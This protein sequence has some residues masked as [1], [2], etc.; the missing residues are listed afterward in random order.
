MTELRDMSKLSEQELLAIIAKQNSPAQMAE[1]L[2]DIGKSAGVGLGEA[3]IGMAGLPGDV[4]ALA[5]KG[6]DWVGGKGARVGIPTPMPTS[7]TIKSRVEELT[8]PFYEPQTGAG[9]F[10]RGI[11]EQAPGV[12]FPGGPVRRAI[13]V[14]APAAGAEAGEALTGGPGGRVAGALIGGLAGTR[15]ITPAPATPERAR[16][17]AILEGEGV[18]LTA[19]QR[20]GNKPLQWFEQAAADTPFAAGRAAALNEA[21]QRGFSGAVMRRIGA[22]GDEIATGDAVQRAARNLSTTFEDLSARNTLTADRQF[23]NDLTQTARQYIDDVI[24][25]QRTQGRQNIQVIMNDVMQ[26]LISNGYRMSGET[27]QATRSRLGRMADGVRESDPQLSRAI[28]GIQGALDDAMTRSISPADQAAWAEARVQWRNLKALE[29]AMSGAGSS[30]AEG[31]VSPSQL[32]GAVAGQNRTGYARG[33]GD[34]ADLARAG[35]AVLRPLPQSGTAPRQA[36][37]NLFASMA[38]GLAGHSTGMGLEGVL[39]GM[40]APAVAGR[41]MLSRPMQAYLGN[42]LLPMTRGEMAR[43]LTVQQLLARPDQGAE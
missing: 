32:R 31:F 8:G 3:A 9:K 4:Q 40:A 36:A 17:A 11:G 18:P 39:A 38:G 43:R 42:Q 7:G 14:I 28:T 35:E 21:T 15:G 10:A 20:T 29:K 27:Y 6:A 22:P 24:P 19:G 33:Q 5:V 34:M 16:L 25:S 41:V 30:V 26:E 23:A 12:L 37:G 1:T 2:T 13:N